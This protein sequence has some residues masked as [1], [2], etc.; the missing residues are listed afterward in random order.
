MC[1]LQALLLAATCIV[2]LAASV[3]TDIGKLVACS[4]TLCGKRAFQ[5]VGLG[6]LKARLAA[7]EK[8][9]GRYECVPYS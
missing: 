3:H 1:V 9:E 6:G 5:Q 2:A 4:V 7:S 8:G